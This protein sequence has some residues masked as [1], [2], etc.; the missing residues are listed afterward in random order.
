[1]IDRDLEPDFPADATRQLAGIP[2]PAH[3]TDASLRDLRDML[4]CSIDND[5][6]MDLDQLSVAEALPKDAVKVLVAIAD[7]DALVKLGSP[8]DRHAKTNTTSIYTAAKIFPML[9]ERLSTDLTSLADNQDRQSIVIEMSIASDGSVTESNI[10][11]ASSSTTRRSS[12]TAASPPGW[13]VRGRRPRDS[14]A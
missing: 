4:W 9:P 5:S 2:G 14:R 11:R 3:E 13:K 10:Y 12:P 7:V 1:M 6:S 8:I